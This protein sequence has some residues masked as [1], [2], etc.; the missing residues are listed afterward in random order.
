MNNLLFK[1]KL[2]LKFICKNFKK[3]I[4]KYH[5]YHVWHYVIIL[6]IK[7]FHSHFYCFSF[8]KMYYN[9]SLNQELPFFFAENRH[10]Q[11][12]R[13]CHTGAQS[14]VQVHSLTNP[15]MKICFFTDLGKNTIISAWNNP[16]K[17]WIS[18]FTIKFFRKLPNFQVC[19]FST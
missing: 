4:V 7:N 6:L 3:R 2:I 11:G 5:I 9:F 18:P 19:R 16:P 14:S 15:K 17:S 1:K 8:L 12:S 10:S 13:M